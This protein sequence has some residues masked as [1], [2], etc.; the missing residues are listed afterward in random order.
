MMTVLNVELKHEAAIDTCRYEHVLV[1]KEV[2]VLHEP[3]LEGQLS[4]QDQ[5]LVK[6]M[7]VKV[8]RYDKIELN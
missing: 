1:L 4:Y 3:Y 7:D 5:V 2:Q 8:C 6:D